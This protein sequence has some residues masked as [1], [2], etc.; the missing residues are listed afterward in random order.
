MRVV[1]ISDEISDNLEE[2][3]HLGSLMGIDAYELRWLR[4]PGSFR[5]R[6]VG[7]LEDGEAAALAQMARREGVAITALSP[8]LAF[9]PDKDAAGLEAQTAQLERC[10]HLAEALG[11]R[12]IIVQGSLPPQRP[13]NGLCPAAAI[14]LLGQAAACAER[15]GLRL[16]L[17]NTPASFADTGVRTASIVHAVRSAALG[18]SWDPCYAAQA[19]EAAVSEGYAWVAPFVHDVRARDQV[20]SDDHGYEYTVLAQGCMDWTAQFQALA[21]DG[22]QGTVTV[23]AQTEPR[24]LNTMHSLQALRGLLQGIERGNSRTA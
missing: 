17:R 13:R 9:A 23:G 16:L 7:E 21:R 6:R 3:V 15:A 20:L 14:D 10:L 1:V 5:R 22:Y 12:D 24:V 8:G 2:A 4:P 19:G 18:I 11:A